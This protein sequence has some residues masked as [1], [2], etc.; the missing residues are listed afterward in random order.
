MATPATAQA[1]CT[2]LSARLLAHQAADEA[3]QAMRHLIF[4]HDA[5]ERRGWSGVESLAPQVL[6]YAIT[7]AETLAS[8]E[9][10]ATMDTLTA[11]LR[12]L[13]AAATVREQRESLAHDFRVGDNLEVSESDYAQFEDAEQNWSG[14]VP[15]GLVPPPERDD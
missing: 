1:L 8:D 2:E 14:T 13:L 7:Q 6:S 11:K 12:A 9:P 15:A 4:V 3:A 10:S 5:L